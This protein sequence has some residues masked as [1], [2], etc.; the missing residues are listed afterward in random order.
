M[1]KKDVQLI[2]KE[3]NIVP[4]KQLGQNF[5]FDKNT[6]DKI[7]SEAE[8]SKDDVILEIGPGL[9]ALTEKIINKAKKVYAIEIEKRFCSYLKDKFLIYNNIEIIHGDIL[10][11]DLPHHNK[12]VSN[13][14]YSITGPILEKVFFKE[15]P[16][17]GI[18]T[19]EQNLADRIFF[20]GDYSNF[21][22]ITVNVNTFII[23]IKKSKISQ[24]CFY[25]AP[26][27]DLCLIKLN[28]RLNIDPFLMEENSIKFFLN[29]IAGIMPYKNKNIVNAIELYFKNNKDLDFKKNDISHIL[30]IGSYENNKL[31]NFKIHDF[32]EIAKII[33]NWNYN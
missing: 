12:V 13:I 27:I 10:E 30:K 25:P 2:L 18:L 32:L 26:N 28:P 19:I 17:C 11:I 21:S 3:L 15:N 24:R 31:F 7:I 9:G 5:L 23:P 16:P 22:R 1:N 6:I 33:Y 29:F 14:P 20:Q 8:I 4:K